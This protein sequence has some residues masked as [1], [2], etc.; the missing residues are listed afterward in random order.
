MP[1]LPVGSPAKSGGGSAASVAASLAKQ[2]TDEIR[3]P[4]DL[5][6]PGTNEG[7]G[8][9]GSTEE[10]NDDASTAQ[11]QP[12]VPELDWN[13]PTPTAPAA[14]TG[15]PA[16]YIAHFPTQSNAEDL[17]FYGTNT[18][19]G[20]NFFALNNLYEKAPTVLW[21]ASNGGIDGTSI[22]VSKGRVFAVDSYGDLYCYAAAT[23]GL[24]TGWTSQSFTTGLGGSLSAPWVSN[25]AKAVYFGD[26]AGNLYKVSTLTGAL[27]W[28]VNLSERLPAPC[29]GN[30][31]PFGIHSSPI[32]LGNYVY[33][34]NDAG[35]MFRI[36]DPGTT[37]PSVVDA[38][39]L[40]ASPTSTGCG[41]A[42]AV[43]NGPSA[44]VVTK[45]IYAA[46]NGVMFEYAMGAGAWAPTYSVDLGTPAG[47]PVY[48]SPIVDYKNFYVYVGYYNRLYKVPYPFTAS[49]KALSS[50][51][52]GVG[53]DP[54]YP[55]S[56]VLPYN[57]SLYIGDGAGAAEMFGCMASSLPPSRTAQTIVYGAT[58]DT[59][60]VID[61]GTGNINFGYTNPTTGGGIVQITQSAIW[62]CAP[63]KYCATAGCGGACINAT[64]C[65]SD[66]DCG[67]APSN[68][69]IACTNNAC[70]T[71]CAAGFKL[72]GSECIADTAC[73]SNADCSGATSVCSGVGGSCVAGQ[74][75]TLRFNIPT[76]AGAGAI[77]SVVATVAT[78]VTNLNTGT[79]TFTQASEFVTGAGTTFL[80]D[81]HVGQRISPD[82]KNFYTILRIASN[83]SMTLAGKFPFATAKVATYNEGDCVAGQIC[84]NSYTYT[85]NCTTS[86]CTK[87]IKLPNGAYHLT[88]KA[89]NG[90]DGTGLVEAANTNP[91]KFRITGDSADLSTANVT[92]VQVYP[93]GNTSSD[94]TC[95][96]NL[97]LDAS[98]NIWTTNGNGYAGSNCA[99]PSNNL[100]KLVKAK[101][102]APTVIGNPAIA[103]SPE[104]IAAD[105]SGNVWFT[106]PSLAKGV[107]KIDSSGNPVTGFP[108]GGN[109]TCQGPRG[110]AYDGFSDG[111]GAY[112]TCYGQLT[113]PG[114]GSR[115]VARWGST[116]N[117][118]SYGELGDSADQPVSIALN[119]PATD[120]PHCFRSVYVNR[121]SATSGVVS[122]F[123]ADLTSLSSVGQS[124]GDADPF[125]LMVDG[126]GTAWSV[127]RKTGGITRF[128]YDGGSLVQD[129]AST[130]ARF[131]WAIAADNQYPLVG[132]NPHRCVTT[133]AQN[134][135]W[136]SNGTGRTVTRLSTAMSAK[137]TYIVGSTATP[138]PRGIIFD[139]GETSGQAGNLWVANSAEGTLS[140]IWMRLSVLS[141]DN[142]DGM[143]DVCP[144]SSAAGS[145]I[146]LSGTGFDTT[147]SN[148]T[149]LVAGYLARV[150][151]ATSTSLTVT[152]PPSVAG[153]VA[154]ITVSNASGHVQTVCTYTTL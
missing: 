5:G 138:A 22:V 84:P 2:L 85:I 128:E 123:S 117:L 21:S 47:Y 145:S 113:Y 19:R 108:V 99:G 33:V 139:S 34:G 116:G 1:Q 26:L 82:K 46:A 45:T 111:G 125:G 151:A 13:W 140:R 20:P 77:K 102:Y 95:P 70:A 23:G 106:V 75:L 112:T 109:A 43:L 37:R 141:D 78:P 68:G 9:A 54:S 52:I 130:L 40:C 6:N 142:A 107:F 55:R 83:T 25:A 14:V 51:M 92:L 110:I 136:V 8:D 103:A 149:V 88:A 39:W 153:T 98:G 72:C 137:N 89:Y 66:A 16:L 50:P 97:T 132:H 115:R 48:S 127:A 119:V 114:S 86:P 67:I 144:V 124:T 69:S 90:T 101:G 28:S 44:D 58:I 118:V 15:T 4:V 49:T 94:A 146:T 7:A 62:G 18:T 10:A 126:A 74:N 29:T 64:D 150:T 38:H 131:P 61:F 87:S 30:C 35:A 24:C 79:A 152:M 3:R 53:P 120:D 12:P 91:N 76:V 56:S 133:Y 59:A 100:T 63:G 121:A 73:C 41:S 36:T 57:D 32:V 154:P 42:W 134:D 60:P 93:I 147:A 11:A 27:V 96:L 143:A 71:T 129:S 148:N 17:L 65:C 104:G 122:R 135:L 31:G 81:F 105:T 80:N